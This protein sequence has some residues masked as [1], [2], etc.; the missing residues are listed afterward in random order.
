[1]FL[2]SIVR[3]RFRDADEREMER[4]KGGRQGGVLC[5]YI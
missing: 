5:R 4:E 2:C 3:L 1:M